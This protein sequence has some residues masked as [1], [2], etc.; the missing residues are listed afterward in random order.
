MSAT[1]QR[2]AVQQHRSHIIEDAAA[3]TGVVL[4]AMSHAPS[5]RL[6]KITASF[7]RHMHEFAREVRLTEAEYEVGADFL[8]RIGQAGNDKHNEGILFADAIGF[9]TLVCL[10]NN[11]Q[12]GVTETASALLGPFGACTR[13]RRRMAARSCISMCATRQ[14]A[15]PRWS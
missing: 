12:N 7:V 15:V 3:V 4:D 14:W 8:N 2:E 9:S 13:P 5:E 11:G 10:L 6:P 1:P